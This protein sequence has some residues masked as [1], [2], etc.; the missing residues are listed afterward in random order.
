MLQSILGF[1]PSNSSRLS[2]LKLNTDAA[3]D[4]PIEQQVCVFSGGDALAYI[5]SVNID[6]QNLVAAVCP[7]FVGERAQVVTVAEHIQNPSGDTI[8]LRCPT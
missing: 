4:T 3:P 6:I 1:G 7:D 2:L 5:G 8:R